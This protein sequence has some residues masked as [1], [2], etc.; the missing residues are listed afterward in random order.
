MSGDFRLAFA[1]AWRITRSWEGP[2]GAVSP[3]EAPSWFTAEPLIVAR[4]VWPFRFASERRSSTR[5]PTPSD[6]AT[7]SA[8]SAKDLQRPSG[9]RPRWALKAMKEAGLAITVTPPARARPHSPFRRAPDA[10]CMATSEEE[11]AVSMEIAGPSR[12]RAYERRP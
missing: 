8:P 5:T 2:L 4:I 11:Q 7:P 12:P 10:R 9:A 3:L 1:S 6:Q